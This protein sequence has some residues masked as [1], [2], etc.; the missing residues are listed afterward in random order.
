[1]NRCIHTFRFLILSLFEL[2]WFHF[3]CIGLHFIQNNS[4]ILVNIIWS[5]SASKYQTTMSCLCNVS[6]DTDTCVDLKRYF[7]WIKHFKHIYRYRTGR[8][9]WTSLC[10]PIWYFMEITHI[11]HFQTNIIVET[12]QK[13][14]CIKQSLSSQLKM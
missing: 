5:L 11:F 8:V 7:L 3:F 2:I 13:Q 14:L 4:K 6:C 9:P 1:M 10:P 12:L